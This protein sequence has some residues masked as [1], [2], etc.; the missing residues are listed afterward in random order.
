MAIIRRNQQNN[1]LNWTPVRTLMDDFV[2][3]PDVWE[4]W[5]NNFGKTLSS[6]MWEDKDAVYIKVSLPGVNPDEVDISVD[7]DMVIVKGEVKEEKEDD[8][9]NYY[10]K[11]IR[12]GSFMQS[13]SVP[14]NVDADN[15]EANFDKGMLTIKLPKS[16]ETKPKQ[17]KI[18]K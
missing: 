3:L 16:E 15:A 8:Q 2:R 4:D 17:I 1:S 12:T 10:Q 9:K 6:D 14:S 11:Q 13:F 18:N 5:T 7:R